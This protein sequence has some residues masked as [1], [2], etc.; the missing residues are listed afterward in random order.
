MSLEAT[1]K[2]GAT[3]LA[4][5]GGD[6]QALVSLGI[7]A[8]KN[9]VF[10]DGDTDFR[11]RRTIDFTT[12][13]P[14]VQASAPN[15]YTQARSTALLKFPLELDNGERTVNT[16]RIEVAYDP[17]STAAEVEEMLEVAGQV[18]GTSAFFDFW[19]EHNLS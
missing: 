3:A 8:N 19:K 2:T 12:K 18:V 13:A 7:S 5:T 1:I 4:A 14:T 6:D 15:G 17:E 11:T 10:F 16:V 9:V